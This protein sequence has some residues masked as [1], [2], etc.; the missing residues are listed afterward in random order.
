MIQVNRIYLIFNR[1]VTKKFLVDTSDVEVKSLLVA[2]LGISDDRNKKKESYFQ[3]N[4]QITMEKTLQPAYK[5][6]EA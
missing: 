1:L 5:S 6:G 4:M 2:I 3:K